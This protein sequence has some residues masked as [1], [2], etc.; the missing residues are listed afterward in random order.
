MITVRESKF[1]KFE[2][3]VSVEII[4]ID[5]GS[6]SE[7]PTPDFIDGKYLYQGS[8]AHDVSTGDFYCIDSEGT[9]YNQDGSGAYVPDEE[10]DEEDSEP[11]T[12]NIVQLSPSVIPGD[13]LHSDVH[14]PDAELTKVIHSDEHGEKTVSDNNDGELTKKVSESESI[15]DE[16]ADKEDDEVTENG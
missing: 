10:E 8:I 9:W 1:I 11:D 12:M 15:S 6:A 14:S 13:G 4:E 5:I 3:G 7:L 16:L 2:N